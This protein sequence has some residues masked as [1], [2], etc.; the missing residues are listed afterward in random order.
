MFRKLASSAI[1]LALFTVVGCASKGPIE[2]EVPTPSGIGGVKSDP[3]ASASKNP[4]GSDDDAWGTGY[5]I[6]QLR[7][8][9]FDKNPLE[10]D[11]VFFQYNSSEIDE[12]SKIIIEAHQRFLSKASGKSIVLEGHADERGT[13]EYNL[14]L[15]ERRSQTVM[16]NFNSAGGVGANSAQTVSYGE[17]RPVSLEQNDAAFEANRRVQILY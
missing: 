6:D 16:E 2:N 5:S 11:T 15:G 1:V 12:R 13:R 14:A 4:W 17:E 9:G 7:N 8:L 3:S 10:Y